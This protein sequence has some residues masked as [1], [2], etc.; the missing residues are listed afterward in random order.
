MSLLSLLLLLLLLWE[1]FFFHLLSLM[2]WRTEAACM[3]FWWITGNSRVC[4]R[5]RSVY[6]RACEEIGRCGGRRR[7]L[8]DGWMDLHRGRHWRARGGGDH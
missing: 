6:T 2:A 3:L 1:V 8:I 4:G 7:G 5:G